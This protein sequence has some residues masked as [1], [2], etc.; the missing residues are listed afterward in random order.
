MKTYILLEYKRDITISK[1]GDKLVNAATRDQQQ[2]I[3]TIIS[4][5]EQ[6]DPTTNKQ[7][8]EW[9]AR[10]Y[11]KQQFRLE[12]YPRVN[13]IVIKFEQIKNKLEQKDINQYTFKTLEE[14]IDKEF[15]VK[16]KDEV[17][18]EDIPGAKNLYKGPLGRLDVPMAEEAAKLLGKGTKWCTA[19]EKNNMFEKYNEK[20]PLYVW[21]DK[22]GDKYQFH[23][24]TRQFMDSR[25][26][27]IS[28]DQLTYFRTKHPV[29]SKLFKKYEQLCLTDPI[30]TYNY[31]KD[32]I[33]GRWIEAEPIIASKPN[34]AFMYSRDVMRRPWVDGEKAIATVPEYAYHYAKDIIRGRFIEGE[35][36]IASNPTY[37]F[38]YKKLYGEHLLQ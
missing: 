22:S 30:L 10:Q 12:D 26:N 17:S 4:A 35:K 38:Q 5:L 2:D 15:N 9:L 6:M 24:E 1:L 37:A 16:L 34:L 23:F 31:I 29:I 19:A 21:R 11:I 14:V 3:D 25:D 36:A 28:R 27:P 8:V 13:D 18:E 7:Y 20:G 32:V 33:E